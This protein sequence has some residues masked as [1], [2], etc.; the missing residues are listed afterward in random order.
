MKIDPE[1]SSGLLQSFRDAFRGLFFVLKNERNARIHLIVS[2]LVAAGGF[3]FRISNVEWMVLILTIAMV[4]I[5]EIYNTALERLI[6]LVHPEWGQDAGT[7]KDISAAGVILS[8]L[9]SIIVGLLIFGPPLYR[10]AAAVL[11]Y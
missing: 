7:C 9:I 1:H 5:T 3:V 8:A 2:L 4:W 10:A 11:N 6:N